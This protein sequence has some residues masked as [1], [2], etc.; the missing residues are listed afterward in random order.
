MTG[1][2][3]LSDARG[4][5]AADVVRATTSERADRTAV[6]RTAV[7]GLMGLLLVAPFEALEPLLRLPGQSIS[8]VEAVFVSVCLAVALAAL[9]SRSLPDLP[10]ADVWPWAALVTAAAI[11]AFR[12]TEFRANAFHMTA[13]LAMSAVVFGLAV[14]AGRDAASRFRVMC[15]AV[16]SGAV[17]ALLV[18][19]DF[20]GVGLVER[21]LAY[22]RPGVAVVGA[23]IRATGPFQ[24]P[25]IASMYLEVA[26][27]LGLGLLATSTIGAVRG[28]RPLLLVTLAVMGEA[29][30][31]TFTRAGLITMAVSLAL[32][33]WAYWRRRGAD[34]VLTLMGVLA[35]LI[36]AEF[37]CSRS[38]EMLMLRMTSE[39]QGR[40][41]R[42]VIDGP[43]T[44]ALDTTHVIRVPLTITNT[45]R[46]T[47]D[48]HGAD[49]VLLSYHWIERDSDAIVAWEGERTAFPEP[50]KPGQSVRIDAAVGGPGRAGRFRLM[51]DIE[52]VQRLWF[53]TEPDA[54]PV[55][56]DG[57]VS[58]PTTAT[59][60]YRGN[61]RIPRTEVRPGRLVLWRGALRMWQERPWLGVG[62][63]NYRLL[64]GRYTLLPSA[65]PRV[66]SN[67]MYLEVLAGTGLAGFTA[68]L[69][70][71]ARSGQ[72]AWAC[73]RGRGSALGLGLAAALTA[74]AVHG[75]VDSFLSFTGTY[76]AMAVVCGLAC[77]HAQDEW[78]HAHRF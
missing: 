41:F 43:G 35:V 78:R 36:L 44:V 59:G 6:A 34:H 73:M 64:Y 60:V 74:C 9:L 13:R 40:W 25:T 46:A 76:I 50:V 58:G 66:H 12:L 75:L 24:Y 18:V 3:T 37:A 63:D 27:A 70:L 16:V 65:D 33:S 45:G 72:A 1:A 62:A 19:L 38:A 31:L 57:T 55:F 20:A 32:V 10:W 22:F 56:A 15:A 29:I 69:W 8:S 5:S 26:F 17:V 42:A 49:P 48:S 77:A 61:M 39:G 11:S 71:G 52:Q 14:I 47:W 28:L 53:S 21:A 67:N 30:I 68:L 4:V 54:V 23:Q 2:R 51:W 7:L